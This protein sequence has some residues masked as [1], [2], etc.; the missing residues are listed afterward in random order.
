MVWDLDAPDHGRLYLRRFSLVETEG[1][2]TCCAARQTIQM[3]L[4]AS[5]LDRFK[6]WSG[7]A[8]VV[9]SQ[10]FR[11]LRTRVHQLKPTDSAHQIFGIARYLDE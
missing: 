6:I 2:N 9:L 3:W 5:S 7:I 1:T 11:L 8:M 4:D 10:D